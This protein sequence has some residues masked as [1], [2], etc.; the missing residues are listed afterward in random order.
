MAK[1]K[2]LDIYCNLVYGG[3]SAKQLETGI[4]GSEEKLIELAEGLAQINW[5]VR[6]YMNGEHGKFN[7]VEYLDFRAFKPME[8]RNAFISFKNVSELLNTIN[9]DKIIHLTTEIEAEWPKFLL[10]AIDGV[11][12]IS[13]YH[14]SRMTQ[15]PKIGFKYLWFDKARMDR[16]FITDKEE[17]SVLYSSSFDRG[18]EDLLTN[19]DLM[20]EKLGVKKLYI[21]YGWDFMVNM[22][23]AR[24][25]LIHWKHHM[26]ELMGFKEVTT[27][28]EHCG[29]SK[30][31]TVQTRDDIVFVGRLTNDEMC[32]MYWQC[33]YWALPLNNPES[34]LFCINAIKAQYAGCIPIVRK[35]GALQET[36]NECYNFDWILGRPNQ[37]NSITENTVENN[38]KFA[39]KFVMT[40]ALEEWNEL[41]T[42]KNT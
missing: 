39:K 34:E 17:G 3:W 26:E 29:Q 18:L 20:K 9:A 37:Q 16:K 2:T 28:C 31:E 4:G 23:K 40:K 33:Q 12:C 21:T 5:K 41:L 36:V 38:R 8:H 35:I 11:Y 15:N 22:I 25:E 32:Q 42:S 7:G 24:P 13:K 27:V 10:D 19:W 14:Q 30:T 6:V 1:R